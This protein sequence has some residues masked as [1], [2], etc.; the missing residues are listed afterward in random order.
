MASSSASPS[1][2]LRRLRVCST[3]A[4][5]SMPCCLSIMSPPRQLLCKT[6]LHSS[7]SLTCNA[8]H[9]LFLF[10]LS[11]SLSRLRPRPTRAHVLVFTSL[12][13]VSSTEVGSRSRLGAKAYQHICY[14]GMLFI[15]RN[16]RRSLCALRTRYMIVYYLLPILHATCHAQ[17]R[18]QTDLSFP[19][20][21]ILRMY[22]LVD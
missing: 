9:A 5:S 20:S 1:V 7:F 17:C 8:L 16:V 13:R 21:R 10:S 15:L 14:R 19:T 3:T 11:L 18:P 2:S 6:C 12:T 4:I 22:P